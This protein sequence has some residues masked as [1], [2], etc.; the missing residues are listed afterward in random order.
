M[1]VGILSK[2]D[3]PFFYLKGSVLFKTYKNSGL[4]MNSVIKFKRSGLA[5]KKYFFDVIF[6]SYSFHP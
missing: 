1:A 2:L 5:Q 6:L 4:S 3:I